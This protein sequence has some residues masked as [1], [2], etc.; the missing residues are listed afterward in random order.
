MDNVRK[1][2]TWVLLLLRAYS[3]LR[4]RVHRPSL[5]NGLHNTVVYSP[6]A[7]QRLYM[8]YYRNVDCRTGLNIG[9]EGRTPTLTE[10]KTPVVK[11]AGCYITASSYWAGLHSGKAIDSYSRC[12]W[13][14]SW[15]GHRLTLYFSILLHWG[16][17]LLYSIPS[18]MQQSQSFLKRH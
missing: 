12:V 17:I 14:E 1:H 11:H 10:N 3:F 2:S 8:L 18:V 13:F 15:Q 4:E 7:W 5:R 16:A 6:I 9:V